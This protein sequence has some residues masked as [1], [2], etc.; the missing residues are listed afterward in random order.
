M[1][2]PLPVVILGAEF[3]AP[4]PYHAGHVICEAEAKALNSLL[5]DKLRS[6]F[7]AKLRKD[8][9]QGATNI[10]ADRLPAYRVEFATFA[11]KYKFQR[12]TAS[13]PVERAARKIAENI[14]KE[15]LRQ[16]GLGPGD[17]TREEFQ[18]HVSEFAGHAG[19]LEEARRRVDATKLV[20]T[21]I[22]EQQTGTGA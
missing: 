12:W 16:N 21:D 3:S 5:A 19:V 11:E 20:L 1:P 7:A 18:S 2:A 13:D 17:L 8:F 10:P 6:S 15:R 4:Q 14:V 22:L 9:G